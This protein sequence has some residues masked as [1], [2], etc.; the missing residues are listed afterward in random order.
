MIRKFFL[1]IPVAVC[2][3]APAANASQERW[4]ISEGLVGE[5]HGVWTIETQGEEL[6]VFAEMFDAEG[7]RTTFFLTGKHENG[8]TVFDQESVGEAP[9][10]AY[11]IKGT[12]TETGDPQS[13]VKQCDGDSEPGEKATWL[14]KKIPEPIEI[15]VPDKNALKGS[16]P[17]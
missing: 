2:A 5:P 3:L 16:D 14:A 17:H 11:R 7:N 4:S 15:P 8:E 13:G 9:K 10:C 1:I 6:K 12:P